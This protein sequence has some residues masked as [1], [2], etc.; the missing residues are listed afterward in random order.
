[1]TSYCA[2]PHSAARRYHGNKMRSIRHKKPAATSPTR[3]C[4][5]ACCSEQS[6]VWL[7]FSPPLFLLSLGCSLCIAHRGDA[8][9]EREGPLND[10]LPPHSDLRWNVWS[11]ETQLS[12][13]FSFLLLKLIL[14]GSSRR[15]TGANK[16]HPAH[17]GI[18]T[19]EYISLSSCSALSFYGNIVKCL[20]TCPNKIKRGK[21]NRSQQ[22]VVEFWPQLCSRFLYCLKIYY[23]LD[24]IQLSLF[25]C[26]L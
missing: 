23:T 15:R 3:P 17:S 1:M 2:R 21:K 5:H 26:F 20:R 7:P 9:T 22:R 16:I 10:V 24:S 19:Y 25:F 12:N 14:K 18:Y 11:L 6:K 8:Q 13:F 4:M